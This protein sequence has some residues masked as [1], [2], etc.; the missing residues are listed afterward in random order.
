MGHKFMI[1]T[2][3]A[4]LTHLQRQAHLSCRQARWLDFLG[5][6]KFEVLHIAGK[7]NVADYF[8]RVPGYDMLTGS[9]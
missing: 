6:F 2:D 3:E 7:K 1:L 5:K 8:S 9:L 4:S